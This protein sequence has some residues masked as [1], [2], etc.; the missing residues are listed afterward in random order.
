MT[1]AEAY[2]H[3]EQVTRT[4]ARN[5]SYG[6][7]LL[8]PAKRSALS[9]VY[10][11]A[12][13]I[14]DIGDEDGETAAK[15]AGLA[16]ARADIERISLDA[17][18]PVL[19]ALADAARRLPIPLEVF[20]ELIDGVEAD[21]RGVRYETA[22]ELVH[23]C[24]CVA[25]SIGRLS[26]GV[27]GG[28]ETPLARDRADALGVALQLTNIL[29][30]VREDLR[31][32][33]IYLPAEDLRRY[34]AELT[35]TDAGEIAG[36]RLPLVDVLRFVAGRARGWYTEGLQLLPMLD[37]RSAACCAAM[38]GIYRRLLDRI[39]ERPDLALEQ[40]LSLPG[41]EKVVVAFGSLGRAVIGSRR[42]AGAEQSGGA[43]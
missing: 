2:A 6:I 7:R 38:S 3:C 24:R 23:Y 5:F 8:P 35:L 27:F 43:A 30:D 19:V 9:A 20:E 1:I 4:E 16:E 18:D 34:D 25:G 22:E 40:R 41:R 11:F 29:R 15:V 26:L 37:P 33:R 13:R 12:R 10:A 39:D 14:D 28:P 36:P 42:H 32:G 17:T 31:G 21:V